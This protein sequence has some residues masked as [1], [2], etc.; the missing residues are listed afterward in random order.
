[1]LPSGSILP[2]QR[3]Q[4]PVLTALMPGTRKQW[5]TVGVVLISICALSVG[6]GETPED[7]PAVASISTQELAKEKHNPF[8]NQITVPIQLSSSL[9][10]G[11]GNGTA[12]GLNVQPAIPIS[13]S[14]DWKL[15]T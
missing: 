9:D 15:I 1:M 11:P 5:H 3:L 4:W 13:L 2:G 8:A 10:V 14:E 6:A 12:G 7:T